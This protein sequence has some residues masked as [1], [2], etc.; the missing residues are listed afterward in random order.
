MKLSSEIVELAIEFACTHISAQIDEKYAYHNLSHTVFVAE[1]VAELSGKLKLDKQQKRIVTVA[2]WFHDTGYSV[3]A[4][5]HEVKGAALVRDFLNRYNIDKGETDAVCSCILS[6]AMPQKPVTILEK[7]ICDADMMHLVSKN[8]MDSSYRL[9]KEWETIQQKFYTD[10]DWLQLNLD[11]VNKHRF[12]TA[13]AIKNMES[14]KQKTIEVLKKKLKLVNKEAGRE[15]QMST[16]RLPVFKYG[17]KAC[18]AILG[19]GFLLTAS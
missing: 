14:K 2:A 10:S 13:Y 12:H 9:R 16:Y 1:K 19:I 8:F 3:E 17:Q 4:D 15:I 7:I 18:I 11:F 5:G 6:T